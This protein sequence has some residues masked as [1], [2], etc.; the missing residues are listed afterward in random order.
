MRRQINGFQ[1]KKMKD[2]KAKVRNQCTILVH[3][4]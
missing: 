4:F 3:K 1:R 2:K